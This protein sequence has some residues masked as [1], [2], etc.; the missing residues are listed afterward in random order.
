MSIAAAVSQRLKDGG[1]ALRPLGDRILMQ[2]LLCIA[3][4]K[5]NSGG[6]LLGC[7]RNQQV[8]GLHLLAWGYVNV[9]DVTSNRSID[10]RLHLHRF[11]GE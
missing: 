10:I 11:E 3:S 2:N 1:L 7:D 9:T 8:F 6:W 5:L 4:G